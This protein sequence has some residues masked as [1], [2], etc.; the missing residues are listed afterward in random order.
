MIPTVL[1]LTA[2]G[3]MDSSNDGFHDG[4]H[5][6]SWDL[7]GISMGFTGI[8][9]GFTGISMG[10]GRIFQDGFMVNGRNAVILM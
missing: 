10:F 2:Q 6:I 3:V 4:F 9:L 1:D 5:G 8:S 7:P